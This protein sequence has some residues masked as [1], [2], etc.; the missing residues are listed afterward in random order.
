MTTVKEF[1]IKKGD[2][3]WCTNSVVMDDESISYVKGYVYG[4]DKDWCITNNQGDTEHDWEGCEYLDHF[5]KIIETPVDNSPVEVVVN[6]DS[7]LNGAALFRAR[8]EY[9]QEEDTNG[10]GDFQSIKL[11]KIDSG[12]QEY[13]YILKSKRWAFDNLKELVDL[14]KK[15]DNEI[16]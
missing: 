16:I 15:F 14:I 2:K 13:Y 7:K 10:V 8:A 1:G 11:E 3:F 6:E 4:S 5:E 9:V 12:N